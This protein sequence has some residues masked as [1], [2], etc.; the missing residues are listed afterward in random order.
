MQTDGITWQ[1]LQQIVNGN[2]G[3]PQNSR[4]G[5]PT[6]NELAVRLKKTDEEV[7]VQGSTTTD[8]AP[9]S[10]YQ[11]SGGPVTGFK[12]FIDGGGQVVRLTGG[13]LFGMQYENGKRGKLANP[14]LCLYNIHIKGDGSSG[15]AVSSLESCPSPFVPCK[16]SPLDR[17]QS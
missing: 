6:N 12:L 11:F 5:T 17:W 14:R 13:L 1:R 8:S 10:A 2:T 3:G 7:V 9:V 15:S 16:W 4:F